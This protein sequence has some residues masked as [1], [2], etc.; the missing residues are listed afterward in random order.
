MHIANTPDCEDGL[1]TSKHK[2]EVKDLLDGH[3][4]IQLV[5]IA[6]PIVLGYEI[7]NGII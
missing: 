6:S 1:V 3:I 4:F 7:F 2:A 5:V